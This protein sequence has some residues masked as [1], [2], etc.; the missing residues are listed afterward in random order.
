MDT[1]S[2]KSAEAQQAP[3]AR[4]SV[5]RNGTT[6][7]GAIVAISYGFILAYFFGPVWFAVWCVASVGTLLWLVRAAIDA[8]AGDV[9]AEARSHTL[10]L[11]LIVVWMISAVAIFMTE[12]RAG[13]ILG[14]TVPASWAIHVIF[15]GKA[16]LTLV[17]RALT[18]C[19]API[20]AFMLY[21]AWSDFPVWAAIPGSIAAIGMLAGIGEAAKLSTRNVSELKKSVIEAS[22]TKERLEFAI[23]SAGD[24]YFEVDLDSMICTLNPGLSKKLMLG[25]VPQDVSMAKDFVHY[26]DIGMLFS[27]LMAVKEG[28]S[29]GWKQQMRVRL[30]DGGWCWMQL[31][32]QRLAANALHG[33]KLIGTVVDVTASKLIEEELRASKEAAEASSNAKSQFLAN[34]SHE[35]RTPLNGVLGMAQAL[36]G[37]DLTPAQKEKVG[38]ILDSGKSLMA[39]LNDVL[40]L[41][42]IEAGKLEIS[43][44]P[45]DFLH[46]M[47]RTRQL[48]QS[49]AEEKG[50]DLFVRYDANFPQRL[51]Y[52]P[53]RVRQCVSNLLSNAIKFT[54]QGSVEVAI[55][56]KPLKNGQYMI[57]VDVS[58]T[59]I[60]MN[61]ATCAKLFT[62]FTQADGATTRKFGGSG[63]GLAISRQ[64]A[65]MMGG[66]IVV[67]SEEGRGS[68][69]RL[70]F[71][72]QEAAPATSPAPT[73]AKVEPAKRTLRGL[74]ILLTDDNAINRQ[75]IKLFLQPQGCD[76][77]EATNGKEA[78]D[79]IATGD[80]DVVLMDIHMPVMDGKEAV[81]RIRANDKWSSLPV[82]ALTADAMSGDR[83]KYL[84]LGM[85][86]YVSKPVDQRE[87]IAKLHRVM[88]L[89]V[90]VP[91]APAQAKSA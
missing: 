2:S 44:V 30:P 61:E 27:S 89:D 80:F 82:I 62:V 45:G 4:P 57:V 3:P 28:Q 79:K 14:V 48:F 34:M 78:L 81:Q 12:S 91:H 41:T 69:F 58:D 54:A 55:N 33:P 29:D 66:D 67:K 88:G 42:K 43:A 32:A 13:W 72:A 9:K 73:A 71:K 60:G 59:G 10:Q 21:S 56:A 25:F 87:L 26:E 52:D 18:V 37:D 16:N 22:S 38:V 46:T 86:D 74:R 85:T 84:A 19:A 15:A 11:V 51:T 63:L 90:P 65:R 5:M 75:V 50:L 83:E 39:L 23:Q 68:T 17:L 6:I 7:T 31:R 40:D 64:L 20:I 36:E 24:G 53:T 77:A 35:I 76:I 49:M 47:K 70:T 8:M 1:V